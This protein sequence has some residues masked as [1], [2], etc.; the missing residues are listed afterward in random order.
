MGRDDVGF[1]SPT[2]A[3]A[4]AAIAVD[5]AT[6]AVTSVA[7]SAGGAGYTPP[8][9]VDPEDGNAPVPGIATQAACEAP[10]PPYRWRGVDTGVSVGAGYYWSSPC[11]GTRAGI[12]MPSGRG[13]LDEMVVKLKMNLNLPIRRPRADGEGNTRYPPVSV[14]PYL[15]GEGPFDYPCPVV[16]GPSDDEG[17]WVYDCMREGTEEAEDEE[18]E[19]LVVEDDE[20]DGGDGDD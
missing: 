19:E 12:C 10:W 9:C 6:G 4:T 7:V 16:D 8:Y 15:P 18:G 20:D 3:N 17:E 11:G 2:G 1:S 5:P 14:L 13:N